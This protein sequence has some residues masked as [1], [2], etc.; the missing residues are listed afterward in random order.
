MKLRNGEFLLP[1]G[2][3]LIFAQASLWR[4][5]DVYHRGELLVRACFLISQE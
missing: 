2:F 1:L 5:S 3:F 4:T